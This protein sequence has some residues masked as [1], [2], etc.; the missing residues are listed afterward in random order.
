MPA[1][2][3]GTGACT[4]R[5]VLGTALHQASSNK[6]PKKAQ[7][8]EKQVHMQPVHRARMQHVLPLRGRAHQEVRMS[9]QYLQKIGQPWDCRP[10]L[11]CG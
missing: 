4:S 5:K 2:G 11:S 7:Q 1:E 8:Q 3:T 9:A 6:A 10:M